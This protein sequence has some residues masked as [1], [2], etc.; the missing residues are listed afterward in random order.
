MTQRARDQRSDERKRA[1]PER[2]AGILRG[3]LRE[4]PPDALPNVQHGERGYRVNWRIVSG[5]IVVVMTGALLLFFISNTFYVHNFAAAGLR[6]L[7]KD[8]IWRW[9]KVADTHLFW[10]NPED[11]GAAILQSPAVAD[12]Q[13]FVGWPP[14]M[15]RITITEREPALIWEQAD[16][17]VWLDIS[18][19]VLMTPPE[20]RGD[21]LR[22]VVENVDEV[23]TPDTRIAPEVVNGA[24]QLRELLPE[25]TTLRY[26]PVKGLGFVDP[27]GWEAWFGSGLDMSVKIQVYQ[28]IVAVRRDSVQLQE[29]NVV[30]PDA[31]FWCCTLP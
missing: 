26:H 25:T 30:N 17:P 14:D 6:Y 19:R 5:A 28:A 27:G 22:V 4:T 23:V 15:V 29:I 18:G 8:E 21:L 20:E 16:V 13:V 11:V 7:G 12:V 10:I 24:L 3:A 31:A 1:R 2:A 9:A